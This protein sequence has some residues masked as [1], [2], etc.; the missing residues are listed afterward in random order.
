VED[1]GWRWQG[2]RRVT[3]NEEGGDDGAAAAAYHL[4]ARTPII[5]NNPPLL[6]PL[7]AYSSVALAVPR[8]C[9]VQL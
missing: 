7:S 1:S 9:F 6:P 3:D 4:I 8:P 5:R 2:V